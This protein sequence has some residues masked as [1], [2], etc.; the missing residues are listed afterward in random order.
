MGFE[1]AVDR[2]QV[3]WL[4]HNLVVIW[5][6]LSLG[7]Y[8]HAERPGTF[9]HFQPQQQSRH[10]L[11]F[12]RTNHRNGNLT[13]RFFVL[14]LLRLYSIFFQ[15]LQRCQYFSGS[16]FSG[17]SARRLVFFFVFFGRLPALDLWI[18]FGSFHGSQGKIRCERRV[19]LFRG[20]LA[21]LVVGKELE[22]VALRQERGE[23]G[24]LRGS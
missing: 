15:F 19:Q 17:F 2:L 24:H 8:R 20:S 11:L 9:M 4:T 14:S 7:V 6:P 5:H 1:L 16:V 10:G 13:C 23:E 18:T 22:G 3:H 12:L 21:F